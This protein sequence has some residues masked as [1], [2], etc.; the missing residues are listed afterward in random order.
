MATSPLDVNL[1]LQVAYWEISELQK[2]ALKVNNGETETVQVPPSLVGCRDNMK[3]VSAITRGH[4]HLMDH[5]TAY[6]PSYPAPADSPPPVPLPPE[7]AS[8]ATSTPHIAQPHTSSQ[9]HQTLTTVHSPPPT[10]LTAKPT[11]NPKP[12]PQQMN[13][14]VKARQSSVLTTLLTVILLILLLALIAMLW[15][16]MPAQFE[17]GPYGFSGEVEWLFYGAPHYYS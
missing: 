4:H 9:H 13:P 17:N 11:S 7:A 16:E 8:K 3:L 6:K 2:R 1:E 14:A 15:I 12:L 10:L 5:L